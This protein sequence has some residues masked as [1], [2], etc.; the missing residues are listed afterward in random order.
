M[1][2]NADPATAR[3]YAMENSFSPNDLILHERFGL[4]VIA[5]ALSTNKVQVVFQE[6]TKI[7][8]MNYKPTVE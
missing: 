3:P 8:V 6:Q 5:G 7:L 4:G 1:L 2:A